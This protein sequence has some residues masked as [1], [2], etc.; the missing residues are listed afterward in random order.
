MLIQLSSNIVSPTRTS[1]FSSL[2]NSPYLF[3]CRRISF[4]QPVPHLFRLYPTLHTYS[5]VVEYRFPNPYLIF[6]VSTQLSML[7]QWSSNIVA[8]SL[9]SSFSSLPNSPCLFSCRRISLPHPFPHLFRPYPTLH[10]YSVVVEY[11]CPIPSLIFFVP[12]QLSMLIQLSSNIVSPT[13]TSSFSSLPNSPY[14]FSGRRISLPHPFPHLFRPY[15]TLY[16]YSV[17][18]EYRYPIPSL[19]FFV[20]TQLSILIQWSSNIV[21]PSLPSSFSSLPNSV[22]LFSCRRIS[23]PHPFPHLFR[24]YP[25]LPIYSVVVEYRYP[26][27]SLIFFVPTQ[28][29]ILIQLSSNIVTPSLPSSFSSLPISPYLFSCR[30]ISLPNPFGHLF[31]P[32]PTLHTNSVVVEYRCPIP[33]LIFFV[34]TQLSILIQWSSN[35]V[36]PSLPS[37]FSSLPNSPYLFSGRRISL[38]HPFPHLFRNN[39]CPWLIDC[40]RVMYVP[41]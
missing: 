15:P 25:S 40:A 12:T 23:L 17:V 39:I 5:V 13:R 14:L 2:P 9:P 4:P 8:P 35:I 22:Y 6:F 37:S 30:R 20:F 11:R 10:A 3:S 1:S 41:G 27:P 31:R 24:P 34:P 29:C 26:I 21:A 16:T 28:L 38:P 32:Y 18:V 33:S 7:I 36:A 19:I